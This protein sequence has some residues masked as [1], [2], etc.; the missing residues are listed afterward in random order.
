MG[1]WHAGAS[2]STPRA[3]PGAS[4][5]PQLEKGFVQTGQAAGDNSLDDQPP[6]E[7]RA[8]PSHEG[9]CGPLIQG[10]RL[11][12][13]SKA[14]ACAARPEGSRPYQD[15][16]RARLRTPILESSRA[17]SSR[18]VSLRDTVY[19]TLSDSPP[20]KVAPEATST[21]ALSLVMILIPH[22]RPACWLAAWLQWQ[23]HP[24]W[25]RWRPSAARGKPP[26]SGRARQVETTARPHGRRCWPCGQA[27][28][29]LSSPR[30]G[31]RID[32]RDRAH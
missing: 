15:H 17:H 26:G 19:E 8:R 10:R 16:V 4:K 32:P 9:R 31:R 13:L 27:L 30:V 3:H 6:S 24:R 11:S 23:H 2:P 20:K 12:L 29:R 1:G 25:H 7:P 28:S 5:P 14:E 22:S 21:I 18:A